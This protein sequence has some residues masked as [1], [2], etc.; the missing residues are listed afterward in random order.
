MFL[1]FY[2]SALEA[3]L[4]RIHGADI[5]HNDLR[6]DNLMVNDHGEVFIIDFDLGE[7]KK[8]RDVY[9]YDKENTHLMSSIGWTQETEDEDDEDGKEE[10]RD[11]DS[12]E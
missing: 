6:I 5:L 11:A 9:Y 10:D 1:F 4:R 12:H 8:D 7:Y 2:S 3:I